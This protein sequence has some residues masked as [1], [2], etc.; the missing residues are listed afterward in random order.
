MKVPERK[1]GELLV[2]WSNRLATAYHFTPEQREVLNTVRIESY[3]A[4]V[5]ACEQ[6]N[7][8]HK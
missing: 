1:E 8:N 7:N 5:H 3:I 2:E 4:G 6:A